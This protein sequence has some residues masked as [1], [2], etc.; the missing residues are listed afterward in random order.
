MIV[1]GKG[2]QSLDA[3]LGRPPSTL[4]STAAA[5]RLKRWTRRRF[6]LDADA[7]VFVAEMA[8]GLPGCPPVETVV[9]FWSGPQVRH[10]FKFFKPLAEIAEDDLPPGWMKPALVDDGEIACC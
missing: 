8:C 9:A 10:R 4:A 3:M 2:R 1:V 5:T 6:A 7:V